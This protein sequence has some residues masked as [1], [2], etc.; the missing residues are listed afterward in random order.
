MVMSALWQREWTNGSHQLRLETL[1][2]E[3]GG[4]RH[5]YEG[6]L[7][8]TLEEKLPPAER[9]AA[10]EMFRLLVTGSGRK[11]NRTARELAGDAHV[12]E[13]LTQGTLP[14][15]V[16]ALILTKTSPPRGAAPDDVGY[17]FAHDVLAEAGLKL[18]RE[19]AVEQERQKVE[20]AELRASAEAKAARRLKLLSGALAAALVLVIAG[21]AVAW[22]FYRDAQKAE[23]QAEKNASDSKQNASIAERNA[24]LALAREVV[25]SANAANLEHQFERAVLLASQAMQIARGLDQSLLSDAAESLRSALLASRPVI[26]DGF[27]GGPSSLS[28][29]PDGKRLAALDA[30]ALR[31]FDAESGQMLKSYPRKFNQVEWS[32]NGKWLL[33]YDSTERLVLDPN[34]GNEVARPGGS[35][36]AA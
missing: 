29:A 27:D 36:A 22:M 2:K 5:I 20:E 3:L 35:G 19:Q 1:E 34:N 28:W 21:A 7:R 24:S 18:V 10:L 33:L 8:A 11:Q 12:E 15:L 14:K 4:A 26:L 23:T 16:G 9:V 13:S 6:H 17:E 30:G 32:P 31:I 25:Q